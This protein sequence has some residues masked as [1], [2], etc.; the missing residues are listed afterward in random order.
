MEQKMENEMETGGIW[1]FKEFIL[2]HK[3]RWYSSWVKLGSSGG[4]S[5]ASMATVVVKV[6]LAGA[7]GAGG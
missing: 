6:A 3:P 1:E 2:N 7:G 5:M 4:G